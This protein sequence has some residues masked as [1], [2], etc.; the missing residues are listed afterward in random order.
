VLWLLIGAFAAWWLGHVLVT[1]AGHDRTDGTE[2]A[3]PLDE[4]GAFE[5]GAIRADAQPASHREMRCDEPIPPYSIAT[6]HGIEIFVESFFI[7]RDDPTDDDDDDDERPPSAPRWEWMYRVEL[8]NQGLETVQLFTRHWV[9]V[10]LNAAVHEV[11]GP[12]AVGQMPLIAP[13]D[14]WSYESGTSLSTPRGSMRGSF[15]LATIR[16]GAA[17]AKHPESG[18]FSARV[19][20]LALSGDGRP[21]RVPCG[22]PLDSSRL[23]PTSV[24]ISSRVIVGVTSSSGGYDPLRRVRA[25][26][27]DVQVNNARDA[28]ILL[29]GREWRTSDPHGSSRVVDAGEHGELVRGVAIPVAR[30]VVQPGAAM[31][32]KAVVTSELEAGIA[33]GHLLACLDYETDARRVDAERAACEPVQ[34]RI[35]RLAISADDSAVFVG[36]SDLDGEASARGGAGRRDPTEAQ[37]E[38]LNFTAHAA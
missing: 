36:L 11:M 7:G 38:T 12:G 37:A 26:V 35:G 10:D 4:L 1:P 2:D 24:A 29:V 18:A 19:G 17:A 21:V 13:G 9:F 8:R 5:P 32:F 15:Q 33:S 34:V 20:R 30:R 14:R 27:L 22:P 23:P 25:Y 6:T 3:L 28:P 31:R 16:T